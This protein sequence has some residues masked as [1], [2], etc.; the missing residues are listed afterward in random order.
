V[1]GLSG[2]REIQYGLDADHSTICKFE[3]ETS[4]NYRIVLPEI[5][6]LVEDAVKNAN[7]L[8]ASETSLESNASTVVRR[9]STRTASE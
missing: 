8:K 6:A 3:S 1:L 4:D 7:M 2:K 5:Q 9:Q